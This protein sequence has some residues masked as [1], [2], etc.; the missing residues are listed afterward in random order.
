VLFNSYE[1]LFLF[2]PLAL[3]AYYG[4][5]QVGRSWALA[6]IGIASVIFY[7]WWNPRDVPLLLGSVLV[8][9]ILCGQL[10]KRYGKLVLAGAIALNLGVLVFFKWKIAAAGAGL[11]GTAQGLT[12]RDTILPL[13]ISFFTF[14]QIAYLVD[15]YRTGTP[16]AGWI[17]Y[18]LFVT[19]FPHLLAGPLLYHGQVMPQFEDPR[20]SRW[21]WE[22]V[23]LGLSLFALGLFKKAGLADSIAPYAD[24]LFAAA[25]AGKQ[26][27][28]FE[29]WSAALAY[30]LQLYFDFSG[31]SDM[32]IGL[33]HLFG[34]RLP[35][36]FN[37]PYQAASLIDFWR[38]WHISLSRFLRE[39]VYIPL[40]GNR[41]GAAMTALALVATML[42]GGLWHGFGWTFLLWGGAHGVLLA[43]NHTWQRYRHSA[44]VTQS[45]LAPMRS[46]GHGALVLLTFTAVTLLWVPFRADSLGTAWHMLE[47][48]FGLHG[49]SLPQRWAAW[50]HDPTGLLIFNGV[51]PSGLIEPRNFV[52]LLVPL[53]MIVWFAPNTSRLCEPLDAEARD[54]TKPIAAPR[55][56]W[57]RALIA[58]ALFGGGLILMGQPRTFLYFT[59]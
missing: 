18:L 59:F 51:F 40:G 55:Y 36:N 31:Y 5:A 33:S 1:F 42:L 28:F 52:M 2:L 9:Y 45:A 7:G 34:I 30:G 35:M 16:R 27:S 22:R 25:A 29:A 26:L 20:T 54:G 58:G 41:H 44:R 15:I 57:G 46:F 39:Y 19:Y 38:R 24:T 47:S 6:A 53:T 32:A 4:F 48:M 49:I 37:S 8:N 23:A 13:G 10:G 11:S 14:T 56:S 3:G 50:L 43:I 17:R 21:K 12:L